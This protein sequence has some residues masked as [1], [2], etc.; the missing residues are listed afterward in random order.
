MNDPIPFRLEH[1]DHV[2]LRA[3]D[4]NTLVRFYRDVL[5]CMLEREAQDIGL[6][7]LRAGASLIDI[8]P[9][10]GRLGQA[11]GSAPERGGGHNVDHLCLRVEPFD[12]QA[13][14]AHLRQYGAEPSEVRLVYGAGGL[15]PSIYVDDPEGNTVELKG[16]ATEAAGRVR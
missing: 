16:P 9:V 12:A 15:G 10:D 6:T 1:L 14:S 2:V 11:G 5:G 3:R 13:I 4:G 7:Q 8:V